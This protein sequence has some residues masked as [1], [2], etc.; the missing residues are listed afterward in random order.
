MPTSYRPYLPDQGLLLPASLSEWLPEDHLAYFISDAVDALDL[1]SFHARYEGDGRRRQPYDPRMMV[2]VLIYGYASGVFSSRKMARKLREDVAFRLLCANNYPAHRTIREFRQLHLKEFSALFVQVVGLAREAGLVSLGRVGVDGTKIK[3]NA[4]KHKAMSYAR[5][6]EEETRLK[7]EIA[8]LLKQAEAQDVA[9]E[10]RDG[11]EDRNGGLPKE[12]KRRADRLKVIEQAKARLEER[13]RQLDKADAKF[14][15]EEGVTRAMGGRRVKRAYGVPEPSAQNNFT[16]PDSRIMVPSGSGFEQCYNAQ[17]AVDE[18]SQLI[19]AADL[20]N[21]A[22]D[23]HSLVPMVL[24]VQ[25]NTGLEPKMILADTG[26]ASESAFSSLEQMQMPACVA[27]GREDKR[28]RAVMANDK[29]A[30][31]RMAQ[32]LSTPEGRAHYRRRKIIPEPVFGWIKQV[33]GFRS[34]SL[35]GLSAVSAEWRLMCTAMNLRRLHRLTWK[36]A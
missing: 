12:L 31:V 11:P 7:R 23:C 34:F 6:Q 20:T 17:A 36:P 13:Q 25:C 30:T 4:S 1:E 28:Q 5:M 2:K 29:P 14:V 8:G 27:L 10:D 16:D 19:V 15:D 32:R 24:Q 26:Y 35:R 21:S 18:G 9:D 33:L 22:S 3:A